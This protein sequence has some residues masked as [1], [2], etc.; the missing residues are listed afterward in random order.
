MDVLSIW[1]CEIRKAANLDRLVTAIRK[2]SG[3]VRSDGGSTRGSN[4]RTKLKELR[5][6][7]ARATKVRAREHFDRLD[8]ARG[9]SSAN[10]PQH[11]R[12]RV[13]E[14]RWHA[15]FTPVPD[16]VCWDQCVATAEEPC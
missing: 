1:E 9:R 6:L 5:H 14:E 8:T 11:D 13:L 16:E 3:V 12:Q 7:L 15:R 10:L 4:V 2:F